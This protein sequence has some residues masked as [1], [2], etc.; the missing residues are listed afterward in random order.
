MAQIRVSTCDLDHS[1][2]LRLIGISTLQCK[3]GTRAHCCSKLQLLQHKMLGRYQGTLA[4][5]EGIEYRSPRSSRG[6]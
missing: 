2:M 3:H 4:I 5:G 1:E 6:R